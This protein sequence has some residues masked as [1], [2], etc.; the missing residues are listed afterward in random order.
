MTSSFS[1]HNCPVAKA[2]TD[3][4]MNANSIGAMAAGINDHLNIDKLQPS[5]LLSKINAFTGCWQKL[6]NMGTRV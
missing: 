2:E 3:A 4:V 6:A 1:K 5:H